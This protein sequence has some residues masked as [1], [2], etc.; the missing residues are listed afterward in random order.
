MGV[1]SSRDRCFLLVV[2]PGR[3]LGHGHDQKND[4]KGNEDSSDDHAN[5]VDLC[6]GC[7]GKRAVTQKSI[8]DPF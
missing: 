5:H 3:L 1:N 7:D 2:F 8:I 6:T 4:D